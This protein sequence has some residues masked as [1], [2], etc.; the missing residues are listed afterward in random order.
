MKI[1]AIRVWHKLLILGLIALVLC[2]VPTYLYIHGAN[3]EIRT[4][5]TE[6]QGLAPAKALVHLLQP[7]QVHRGLSAAVLSGNQAL[8]SQRTSKQD[9]V[10]AAFAKARDAIPE[11]AGPVLQLLDKAQADWKSLTAAL[12]EQ[13][14]PVD[15][16][17]DRHTKLIASLL[18]TLETS[19]EHFGLTL[20]PEAA[21]Y[22]LIIA[23]FEDLPKL[24]EAMGRLRAGGTAIL[25]IKQATTEERVG[26][27]A[28]LERTREGLEH[29]RARIQKAVST[30]GG[31]LEQIETASIAALNATQ[32]LIAV[33]DLEFMRIEVLRYDAADYFKLATT[34]IDAQFN[35]IDTA[36][37]QIEATLHQRVSSQRKRMALLL[38]LVG[39]LLIFGTFTMYWIARSITRPLGAAI[40]DANAIASGDLATTIDHIGADEVGQLRGSMRE[41]QTHLARI[42]ASIR[43]NSEAVATAAREI[44]SSTQNMSARAES[45]ASSLEQTAASMEEL[46]ATFHKNDESSQHVSELAVQAAKAAEQGGVVVGKVTA[47]M[48]EI[49]VASKKIAEII[50][51]IDSIAFQTNIL[52]LNAAVEAARA[53]E[54]GRGF[55]VVAAEVRAL[56]QRSAG[57]SKE[58]RGLIGDSVKKVQA[59]T[60][61]TAESRKAMDGILASVRK[62]ADTMN[63]MQ[64]VREDQRRGVSQVSRAV[65]QMNQG[66]QQSAAMVEEIA[67]TADMLSNQAQE[68]IQAVSAF[69]LA[70]ASGMERRSRTRTAHH[71]V[72]KTAP[73][74][75]E[76]ALSNKEIAEAIAQTWRGDQ[77]PPMLGP[78]QT[79]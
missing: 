52:A 1:T 59:G 5:L 26:I 68:L 42:V 9:E 64:T 7:A 55:A 70:G 72:A 17:I 75:P 20:D 4:A 54:Q 36:R 24:T 41:M 16:N 77:A 10:T 79:D 60:R 65:E 3:Q 29:S 71:T 48:Q 43:E 19:I 6:I 67:A 49:D 73:V 34:A 74:L 66:T 56:A 25:G 46:N 23:A 27:A 78:R 62:V 53:G 15:E 37:A 58:I 14:F 63:E 50:G 44:A 47:T 8:L 35:L 21:S 69:K 57:A 61:E 32:K 51:V 38:G 12:K 76:I 13:S 39:M 11:S 45:Q 30:D 40:H 33:T 2:A 18:K 28:M 31:N 22:Y